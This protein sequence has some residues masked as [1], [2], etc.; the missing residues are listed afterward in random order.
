MN[1]SSSNALEICETA[2]KIASENNFEVKSF[3]FDALAEDLRK[4]RVV[5]IGAVQNSIVAETTA[6]IGVQRDQIFKKI[7]KIIEAAGAD[8]VN[9]LC[10]QEAWSK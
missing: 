9:V 7:G 6:P 5:K 3:G 10:L 2:K 1:P 4:P 8:N